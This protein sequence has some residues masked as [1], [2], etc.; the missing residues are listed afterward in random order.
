MPRFPLIFHVC[1]FVLSVVAFVA[2]NLFPVV[3]LGPVYFARLYDSGHLGH[4]LF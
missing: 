3:P 1:V 4:D 2:S